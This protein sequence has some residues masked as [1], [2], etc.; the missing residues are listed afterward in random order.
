MA[1]LRDSVY[2]RVNKSSSFGKSFIGIIIFFILVLFVFFLR[3][4]FFVPV[5]P[6][7]NTIRTVDSATYG[8]FSTKPELVK[9]IQ[10]LKSEN[11]E[12][13]LKIA[14]Y[15]KIQNENIGLRGVQETK[16]ITFTEIKQIYAKPGVSSY[17]TLVIE[18]VA[19]DAVGS[20]VFS[21]AGMPLGTVSKAYKNGAVVDL[22]SQNKRE[23]PARL[24]LSDALENVDITLI[25]NSGASFI[26]KV[27]KSYTVPVWSLVYV[28]PYTKPIAQVV[29][30]ETIEDTQ[31]LL[32]TMRYIQNINYL[33]H[34]G[35]SQN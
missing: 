11:E 12:L 33:S 26:A 29:H 30:V 22:Y 6:V 14:D 27:P 15:E 9:K 8:T 10:E 17:D 7:L 5:V 1:Y 34:V 32:L 16:D 31:Q 21:L 13:R 3:K 23:L 4:Y 18:N 28:Q 35:I 2:T 25:G 24:V 19:E 20:R